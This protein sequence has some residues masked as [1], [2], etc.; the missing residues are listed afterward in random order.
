METNVLQLNDHIWQVGVADDRDR[1][2]GY[3]IHHGTTYNAYLVR[4]RSGK[5]VLVDTVLASFS[6]V[7]LKNIRAITPL[8]DIEAVIVNHTE[9]DHSGALPA[10][11]RECSP[12]L[13]ATAA[14]A[15]LLQT[16]YGITDVTIVKAGQTETLC[17]REFAF[18][19]TPMVH[20][21]DNMVTLLCG[22]GILLSNDAF[23]QHYASEQLLDTQANVETALKEARHYFANI[24]LPFKAQTT[25]ALD[26]ALQLNPKIVAPSHGVV[27]TKHLPDVVALYKQLCGAPDP[28]VCTLAFD[29]MWGGTADL[30]QEKC[31]E[32]QAR[33][34]TVRA[35]DLRTCHISDVI[36]SLADSTHLSLGSPTHYTHPTARVCTLLAEIQTLKP[37]IKTF[38][39]FGTSGWG[40]G[41]TKKMQQTLQ[42]CGYVEE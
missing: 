35:F 8:Q 21:P 7:L 12:R 32:L 25:K 6:D 11:L 14:A 39:V 17:G 40:G 29:S 41:A 27:W 13:Y 4:G 18:Y 15:K 33:Y 36:D 10:L 37:A 26:A 16:Q 30:A 23:G 2:H 1:F 5:Y 28:D 22:E 24:V 20:W 38:S 9:P 19:P 42:D 3:Y 31:Q 34:K